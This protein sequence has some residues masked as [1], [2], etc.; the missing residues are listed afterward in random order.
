MA[1]S[2]TEYGLAQWRSY[3]QWVRG[4]VRI[5]DD[6][7]I[8]DEDRAESYG[9]HER[10]DNHIFIELG[11]LAADRKFDPRDVASFVRR[12]GLL[13]HG[14]DSIGTGECR[15]PLREWRAESQIMGMLLEVYVGLKD[16]INKGSASK[17][18]EVFER[19]PPLSKFAPLDAEDQQLIDETSANLAEIITRKL[20]GCELGITSS[21]YVS[22]QRRGPGIFMQLQKPPHL[23][24]ACY[25]HLVQVMVDRQ[26]LQECPGCGRVFIPR[27]G[28]Q[29]YCSKGCA[30]VNRWRRWKAN[31]PK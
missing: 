8:L 23:L 7:V 21:V 1:D 10:A 26:P 9:I 28:K 6:E 30:D 29:K 12:N 11:E 16:S 25:A 31:Q 5:T 15:E 27:S 3:P 19:F 14:A 24:S 17:L 13:W 4:P 2:D 18:R 22:T 20:E